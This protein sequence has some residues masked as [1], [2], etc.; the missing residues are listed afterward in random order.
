MHGLLVQGRKRD[1]LEKRGDPGE[2]LARVRQQLL[3]LE[4]ER[5]RDREVLPQPLQLGD[6]EAALDVRVALGALERQIAS[7]LRFHPQRFQKRQRLTL[8]LARHVP[9]REGARN[10]IA[11][12]QDQLHRR[13]VARDSLGRCRPIHVRGRHLAQQT[14]R[15][16]RL[17]VGVVGRVIDRLDREIRVG[18]EEVQFLLPP[19]QTQLRMLAQVGIE[20]GR[21]ALLRA[22]DD[23][24]YAVEDAFS[25]QCR[26]DDR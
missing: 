9:L 4:H 11:Q 19:R 17:E 8:K 5:L 10:R 18:V 13:V 15:R 2:H 25:R 24:T 20:R 21:A 3:A 1:D 14:L 6:V 12:H 16:M 26:G 7:P 22:C 23:E